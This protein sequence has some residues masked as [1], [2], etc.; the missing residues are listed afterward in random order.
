M[1]KD[2]A[3][4]FQIALAPD[5]DRYT[6][7]PASTIFDMKDVNSICFVLEEGAGG[8]G[9]TLVQIEA[10]DSAG[11]NEQ[12]LAFRYRLN[13]GALTPCASTGYTTIAGANKIVEF[14]IDARDVPGSLR[15]VKV[16]LTEGDSTAVD[17][18]ILAVIDPR[19]SL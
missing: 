7:S 9:T 6:G 1:L 17:A 10:C 19:T 11:A 13:G 15:H 8:A 2:L 16:Q 14:Y 4:K 5:A 18:S 3:R 12:A